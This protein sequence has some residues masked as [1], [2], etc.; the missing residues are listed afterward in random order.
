[1]AC[2]TG[3]TSSFEIA[4]DPDLLAPLIGVIQE[5]LVSFAIGDETARIRIAV[6]LQESLANA[7][8]HGNLEC[9]SD[10]RQE[11]ERDFYSLVS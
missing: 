7:L 10:L 8:F 2:Q 11:D 4:S 6:A 1:L 9:S 5:D 3:R